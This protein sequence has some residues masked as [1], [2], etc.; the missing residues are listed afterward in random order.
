MKWTTD[1]EKVFTIRKDNLLVSAAAG[2]GKTAVLTERL[3]AALQNKSDPANIDEFL[4]VTFTRA[5]AAEMRERIG[6]KITAALEKDPDNTHLRRQLSLLNRA[7]ITT[8]DGFCSWVVKSYA[9]RIGLDM[10]FRIGETGELKLLRADVMEKIL[11]EAHSDE[12]AAFLESFHHFLEAF[13]PKNEKTVEAFIEKVYDAAMSH[14]YP[15]EWFTAIRQE[16]QSGSDDR[17]ST[18]LWMTDFKTRFDEIVS[19]GCQLTA[20][21]ASVFDRP[22]APLGLLPGFEPYHVFFDRLRDILEGSFSY[23]ACYDLTAVFVKPNFTRFRAGKNDDKALKERLDLN[24]KKLNAYIEEMKEMLIIPP[25]LA[26]KYQALASQSLDVLL[27]LCERFKTAFSEAK[28]RKNIVD[29]ADLEHFALQILREDKVRTAAAVEIGRHFREIMIDEYQDSNYLQEE[30]L[31]AVSGIE[32]GRRNYFC[33]GDVKQ[34]I[35]RFRQ[36]R[37]D[38]FMKKFE[39]YGAREGGTRIDLYQNF[40]S[41]PEIIAVVNAIFKRVMRKEVGGI[42]YDET[43]ALAGGND[44]ESLIN[45]KGRES[46][47][48]EVME[49]MTTSE[50][51]SDDEAL[52]LSAREMEAHAIANRIVSMVGRYKIRTE[53]DGKIVERPL[54]YGDIAILLRSSA[55]WAADFDRILSEAGIPAAVQQ[56]NGFFT[57]YEVT[58]LLDFLSVID[59]PRQDIPL[60]AVLTSPIG[61]LSAEDLTAVK[62]MAVAGSDTESLCFYDHLKVY[63]S[64]GDNDSLKNRLQSLVERLEDYKQRASYTPIYELMTEILEETGFGLFV[65]TLPGGRQREN[66]LKALIEKA[67]VY[68]QTSYVGLFNF[69]RYIR[70]LEKYEEDV[71]V[72]SEG[73]GSDV[74]R[75]VTIHKSK[76]LEYPVVFVSGLGKKFNKQDLNAAILIHPELGLAS[77]YYDIE[78][79]LK[80]PTMKKTAVKARLKR[81]AIGEE[82]RILYVAMTRAR[83]KLILTGTL[84]DNALNK[85]AYP[86]VESATGFMV[87]GYIADVATPWQLLLPALW[88][89]EA[90][91][92]DMPLDIIPYRPQDVAGAEI[93]K[94]SGKL[95][96]LQTIQTFNPDTVVDPSVRRLLEERF[97]WRY[98]YEGREAIPIKVSVSDIKKAHFDDEEG[99]S[100]DVFEEVPVIPLIPEFMKQKVGEENTEPILT[101]S[102]RGT[103]YHD[104][105]KFMDM[106]RENPD[107]AY[108]ESEVLRLIAEGHLRDEARTVINRRKILWFL[109]SFL[110]RRMSEALRD[111]RLY[112]EQPFT[113]RREASSIDSTWSDEESVLIQGIVDAYFEEGNDLVL[114][115]YKTDAVTD[116]QAL[117]DRYRIQ[118]EIYAEALTRATGKK[119][120]ESWIYS[121]ALGKSLRIF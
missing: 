47:Q 74:V 25:D 114:M 119:V 98:P 68:E 22:G 87:S 11:I 57:A 28:R 48:V 88:D 19:S 52:A 77:E 89:I 67:A 107:E 9:S 12:D 105:M 45:E 41:R 97:S 78:R 2:S 66:N 4:I 17:I 30:I 40:R 112:R 15:E 62:T 10:G 93:L 92:A 110:G 90:K 76:G 46:H 116:E 85:A 16:N 32:D 56:K 7:K 51:E 39:A 61:R 5:A 96:R 117:L 42:V 86:T 1:Q 54:R 94:E 91:E 101:G 8:I 20:D 37:P 6:R 69:V 36:A 75:L 58:I 83:L 81:D 49:L 35:Y 100:R 14:P 84:T 3:I 65:S 111:K 115:D 109:S 103:L 73:E 80:V 95:D 38:L 72:A 55:G 104:F 24:R 33:V 44:S 64:F 26:V 71:E 102:A 60:A 63:I 106:S 31:T 121:F 43:V 34:S 113:L 59:N 99:E 82:L 21:C 120:K 79:S 118:L 23:K 13:A 53:E 27:A 18:A 70:H 108:I 29:F 50:A